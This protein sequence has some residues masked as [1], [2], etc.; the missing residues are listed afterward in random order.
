MAAGTNPLG[1]KSVAY[2][3]CQLFT[4]V[5][6]LNGIAPLFDLVG[7]NVDNFGFDPFDEISFSGLGDLPAGLVAGGTVAIASLG[8]GKTIIKDTDIG[9]KN[10]DWND[11][12]V[13][14]EHWPSC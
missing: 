6:K 8:G 10:R 14:A 7:K 9:N 13:T 4:R 11:W 3:L 2:T 5:R 1:I 12:S